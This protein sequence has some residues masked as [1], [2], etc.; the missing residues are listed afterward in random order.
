MII[1]ERSS[2][3]NTFSFKLL[4]GTNRTGGYLYIIFSIFMEWGCHAL[5]CAEMRNVI[6]WVSKAY[7][8]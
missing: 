2:K 6:F 3:S 5:R 4:F 1:K 8:L 7:G